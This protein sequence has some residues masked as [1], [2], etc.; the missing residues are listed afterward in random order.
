MELSDMPGNEKQQKGGRLKQ[1]LKAARPALNLSA[2]QDEK[3]KAIFKNFREKKRILIEKGGDA[4][5]DDLHSA[6]K[7]RK[8]QLMS[9]LND[10]Q[11]KIL[12]D[13]LKELKNKTDQQ[14]M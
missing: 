8:Q 6:K 7:A 12:K 4:M 10:D 14:P 5:D 2:E 3:I 13:H 9:V 1:A 11:K